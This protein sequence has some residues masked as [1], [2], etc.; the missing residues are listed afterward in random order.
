MCNYN[1]NTT[2]Y[3]T[4]TDRHVHEFLGSTVFAG[5]C[6]GCHNH[7]FAVMSGEPVETNGNHYH[8]LSF[9]TDTHDNHSHEYCGST[10]LAIPTGEGRHVHFANGCTNSSDGHAHEFQVV[11]M[12][13]NPTD[14]IL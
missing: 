2:D 14:C 10:S 6:N 8:N 4:Y 11:S 9:F 1:P 12:I 3:C 13:N 7:R 5:A